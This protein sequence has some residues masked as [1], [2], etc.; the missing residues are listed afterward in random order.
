MENRA[1]QN[2]Q[3]TFTI[4]QDDFSFYEKIKV[5]PPTFCP[6]CRL[7]RRIMWRNTRSLYKRFCGVCN[8]NLISMYPD[9][10]AKV[11]CTDC[12]ASVNWNP[13]EYGRDYDFGIPFFK[14][15][16]DQFKIIPRPFRFGFGNLVN[17]DFTNF[18]KDNK[19]AYLSYSVTDCEDV[20]YSETIDKSKNTLD[21]LAVQKSDHCS[22]NVDSEGNYNT[23]YVVKSQNDI[24][25]FFLY[26]CSNC[27]NCCLSSNLRNQQYIFKN[28][29]LSK[30]AYQEAVTKLKL[31]TAS[32]IQKSKEEFDK[33]IQYDAINKYAFIYAS[34]KATGDYIHNAKNIKRSFDTNNSEDIAYSAR[35]FGAKDCYDCN[36]AG[37]GSEGN[38]ESVVPSNNTSKVFFSYIILGSSEC[39]YS[40]N[41]RNCSNC[42]ACISMNNAKYCIFNKQYEKD[43]YFTI[44]EKIKNHMNEMPYVDTKGRIF[45]YGE[46]LPYD[47][48][49]FGYN[50]TN[51]HD[52]FPISEN[53]AKE[54]GYNWKEREKRDY[55]VTINSN[56][57]P[58]SIN[59]VSDSILTEIVSC[60]N[61]GNQMYQCT[62]AFRITENELQFYQNKKLP[63]PRFCPNCR[64]YQR[65]VYRNPMHLYKR[66]CM[67]DKNHSNHEGKC[68]VE[69]ETTYSPD[70]PEKVYCEKCYQQEIY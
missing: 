30:E 61:E 19:N 64:H 35:V 41:L 26:D 58:D 24:D 14:Q 18:S 33:L 6:E 56:D 54:K 51:A 66:E 8:K 27:Q 40:I 53:E 46:Y 29:K 21:C 25:S 52:Y 50:E 47:M 59:D 22:W 13:F 11:L 16:K 39:E 5:P 57:L 34:E 15:L 70:R 12:Y 4:E 55:K 60:P 32:G 43:E 36:G 38:Y 65:L 37:F 2:C 45:K 3:Q 67:C 63:L 69:F 62:T 44:V 7:V 20:M 48:L 42:F 17:S 1:C 49:P 9:G 23:H 68:E 10:D 28:Q 31:D